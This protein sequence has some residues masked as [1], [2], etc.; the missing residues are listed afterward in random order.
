MRNCTPASITG[1]WEN[2]TP[3]SARAPGS[4]RHRVARW[5]W[6]RTCSL[7]PSQRVPKS[8]SLQLGE[9]GGLRYLYYRRMEATGKR[10]QGTRCAACGKGW[11]WPNTI[12]DRRHGFQAFRTFPSSSFLWFQP[13]ADVD[14]RV[15]RF[16]WFLPRPLQKRVHLCTLASSFSFYM[17]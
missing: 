9:P 8:S 1:V 12:P 14:S 11:R 7:Q 16:L 10:T 13:S 2:D 17:K 15:F 6:P 5:P 4:M 3:A